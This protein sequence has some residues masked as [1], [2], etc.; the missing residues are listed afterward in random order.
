MV[1]VLLGFGATLFESNKVYITE[2]LQMRLHGNF[3]S[4]VAIIHEFD[5]S[6]AG[7]LYS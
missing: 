4:C 2:R 1:G 3:I 7:F 5:F 6:I